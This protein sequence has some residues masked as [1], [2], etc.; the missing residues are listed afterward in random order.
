MG[1]ENGP[2]PGWGHGAGWDEVYH[3]THAWWGGWEVVLIAL[4]LAALIGVVIWGVLR[5]TRAPSV[6]TGVA[7]VPMTPRP[8]GALSELRL[9]YARGEIERDAFLQASEDLGEG[10][11]PSVPATEGP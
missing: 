2:G 9:R 10:P 7:T 6:T 5:M 1:G 3:M 11:P 4:L 8:D